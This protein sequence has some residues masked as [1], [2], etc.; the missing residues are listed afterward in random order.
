M[1]DTYFEPRISNDAKA[2]WE[3]CKEK[4]L[5]FQKCKV[6]GHTR[7]PAAYICPECLSTEYNYI[8][9]PSRGKIYSYVKFCYAFHPSVE[10]KLPYY[11]AVIDLDCGVTMLSNITDTPEEKIKCGATVA[12]VWADKS[13]I[14]RPTFRVE[15]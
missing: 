4:K 7:W 5:V 9:V 1:V 12:C 8:E 13:E 15:G 10:E 14:P 3:G 2:F 11:V 6:C